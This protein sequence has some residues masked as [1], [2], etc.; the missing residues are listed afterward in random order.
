MSDQNQNHNHSQSA[1]IETKNEKNTAH[2]Q[3][4]CSSQHA[5][6]PCCSGEGEQGDSSCC[7]ISPGKLWKVL[8]W[9]GL[10]FAAIII[11]ANAFSTKEEAPGK[12]NATEEGF[13]E[14][15]QSD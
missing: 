15:A 12:E 9:L 14:N 6:E 4:C 13:T 3:N 5:S 8:L 2:P 11:I 1:D 10:I 7:G